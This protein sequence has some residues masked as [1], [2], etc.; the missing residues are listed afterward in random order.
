MHLIDLCIL[1]GAN[2]N[3]NSKACR[4]IHQSDIEL[5][6]VMRHTRN[7]AHEHRNRQSCRLLAT[8]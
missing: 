2:K 4:A 8:A 7:M 3:G 6:G 5:H 1:E